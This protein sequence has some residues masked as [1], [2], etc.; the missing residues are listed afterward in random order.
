MSPFPTVFS[1]CLENFPPFS[2][3]LKLLSTNSVSLENFPPFSSHLKLLSAN[4]FSL[5]E[6]TICRLGKGLSFGK[7]LI[8]WCNKDCFNMR[9]GVNCMVFNAVLNSISVIYPC[10]QSTYPCFPRVLLTSTPHNFL[11]K[12]LAAFL[13]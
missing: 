2:S 1:I 3:N 13:T 5:E 6:S 9:H 10:D 8:V 12:P 11:S 7:G 4:S